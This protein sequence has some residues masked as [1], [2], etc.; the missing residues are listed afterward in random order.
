MSASLVGSEMCIR[1]S[2][3]SERVTE[4]FEKCRQHFG[5]YPS[6]EIE[7]TCEQLSAVDQLVHLR[8]LALRGLR[9]VRSARQAGGAQA[10]PRR[11][12]LQ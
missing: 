7:P 10:Q 2:L 11:L 5:D 12:L 3:S 9:P 8:L 1:D 4:M 6:E